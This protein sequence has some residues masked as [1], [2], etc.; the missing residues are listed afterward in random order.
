MSCEIE[1]KIGDKVL[2]I[3]DYYGDDILSRQCALVKKGDII[4][5]IKL[6][7]EDYKYN[8]TSYRDSD[9]MYYVSFKELDGCFSFPNDYMKLH[10]RKNNLKQILNED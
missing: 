10:P 6:S 2:I 3:N 7:K 8:R 1:L 4:T 5:I 9:D